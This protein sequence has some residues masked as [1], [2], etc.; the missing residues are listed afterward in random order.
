MR[1]RWD[2]SHLFVSTCASVTMGLTGSATESDPGV[3]LSRQLQAWNLCSPRLACETGGLFCASPQ[4]AQPA[5]CS[6][7]SSTSRK[8][9]LARRS[10]TTSGRPARV[11]RRD[12]RPKTHASERDIDIVRDQVQE[13]AR[14]F[15]ASPRPTQPASCPSHSSTCAKSSG[16]RPAARRAPQNA[17]ERDISSGTQEFARDFRASPRP[18]QP[19][20]CPSH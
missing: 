11:R 5:S 13:F 20:S 8:A 9:G 2:T 19:A 3:Y 10:R 4:P 7:H 12:E 1:G 6:S 14:D 18:T 17:S 15:R 16:A